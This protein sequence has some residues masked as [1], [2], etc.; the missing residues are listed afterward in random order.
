MTKWRRA[1]SKPIVV[2]FREVEPNW[3]VTE[4]D[5]MHETERIQTGE[6]ALYGYPGEDYIIRG[7]RGEIY[8]IK[9]DV[10]AEM[11]DVIE[12]KPS[13]NKVSMKKH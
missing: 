4:K 11:Y 3:E 5:A 2:E 8:P 6:G 1:R 13:K 7:V 9:K 10:F 12:E